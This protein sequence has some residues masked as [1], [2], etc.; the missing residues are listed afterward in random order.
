MGAQANA[1]YREESLFFYEDDILVMY[2]DGAT[3]SRNFGRLQYGIERLLTVI[4]QKRRLSAEDIADAIC[5]SVGLFSGGLRTD[6]L[7]TIVL[8]GEPACHSERGMGER[9][10]TARR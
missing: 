1:V 10:S 3:E 9:S 5:E 4:T 7:T 6:D 2:T 8:K